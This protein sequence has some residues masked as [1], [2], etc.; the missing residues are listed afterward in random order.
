M[1]KTTSTQARRIVSVVSILL[2]GAA[3]IAQADIRVGSYVWAHRLETQR[4]GDYSTV[5]RANLYGGGYGH[6]D[7]SWTWTME[8]GMQRANNDWTTAA[9][10]LDDNPSQFAGHTGMQSANYLLK[11]LYP[12][13][14]A[15]IKAHSDAGRYDGSELAWSEGYFSFGG[16][17]YYLR[18]YYIS[19]RFCM[20]NFG[21]LP[22]IA[23]GYDLDAPCWTQPKIQTYISGRTTENPTGLGFYNHFTW[24]YGTPDMLKPNGWSDYRWTSDDGSTVIVGSSGTWAGDGGGAEICAPTAGRFPT[25]AGKVFQENTWNTSLPNVWNNSLVVAGSGFSLFF[26]GSKLCENRLLEAEKFATFARP[27]GYQYPLTGD[28]YLY[29]VWGG[30]IKFNQHD[31]ADAQGTPWQT[32]VSNT[33]NMNV[34]DAYQAAFRVADTTL[35][36]ALSAISSNVNTSGAGK[37]VIVYNALSWART[38]YAMV[39]T[40]DLGFTTPIQ[41]QDAAGTVIPCQVIDNQGAAALVFTAEDVPSLGYKEYRVLNSAA[42]SRSAGVTAGIAAGIITLDNGLCTVK[43]NTT[44][45][46]LTSV[47]DKANAKELLSAPGNQI[48]S[49]TGSPNWWDDCCIQSSHHPRNMPATLPAYQVPTS[50]QLVDSGPAVARVKVSYTI[51][52]VSW[53]QFI[54]L[55][56]KVPVVNNRMVSASLNSNNELVLNLPLNSTVANAS[57]EFNAGVAYGHHRYVNASNYTIT[58]KWANV[59]NDAKDYSVAL[60]ENNC[61]IWS[62]YGIGGQRDLR[63]VLLAEQTSRWGG[64]WSKTDWEMSWGIWGHTGDWTDGAPQKG[65]E[66]NSPLI[67]RVESSHGGQ[68]PTEYSFLTVEPE[69]VVV[70]AVKKWESESPTRQ[71][72]LTT[73]V[74]FYEIDGKNTNAVFHFPQNR[75]VSAWESQGNEYGVYGSKLPVTA[76]SAA[77]NVT[78]TMGHNQIRS[79]KIQTPYAALGI[80]GRDPLYATLS[81][82][83]SACV[84]VRIYNGRGQT[85]WQGKGVDAMLSFIRRPGI[86]K[87]LY[88]VQYLGANGVPLTAR[89]LCLPAGSIASLTNY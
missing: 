7:I 36:R 63:L 89:K 65:Y 64:H 49:T 1:G 57:R 14:W 75:P 32:G 81:P 67:S 11:K 46:A 47:Y 80:G 25:F 13:T 54:M 53:S 79:L 19:A 61:T 23:S 59:A 20:D 35:T 52:G 39:K 17:E 74:R 29:D 6:L 45:G 30:F 33:T 44:S 26:W 41:V 70:T 2:A 21:Y 66:F 15:R 85:V 68:L 83:L 72:S 58:H 18:N 71:D 87:G 4:I 62:F 24:N 76:G 3:S 51:N 37:S 55:F 86:A 84:A 22:Q 48:A 60:L 34:Q 78:F 38:D 16:D 40:A 50:V 8:N 43:V 69:N 12:G 82:A 77:Q 56:N 73:Q 9:D 5:P 88:V 28:S 42:P 31:L 27:F 10:C